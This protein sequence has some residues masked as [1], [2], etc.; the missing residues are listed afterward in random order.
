RCVL[1]AGNALYTAETVEIYR[2]ALTPFSHLYHFTLDAD[3]ATVVE[4]V[5]QRGDLT[6]HPPAWLS[7]WLTHI[8]GHY[9]GW[10]H[11][12]DTTNLSVEE[13]LNAIY[14]QLLDLN[15]LSIAG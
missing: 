5:R 8:R 1:I 9:A 4:R 3:L 12:I 6:A 15:H 13:I 2:E 14:A 7:D 11:V 10:T